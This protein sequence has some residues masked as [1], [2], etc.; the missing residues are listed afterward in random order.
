VV[1]TLL[2]VDGVDRGANVL[3]DTST[4]PRIQLAVAED[5]IGAGLE[6]VSTGPQRNPM[7]SD[8]NAVGLEATHS[9]LVDVPSLIQK[10]ICDTRVKSA[11]AIFEFALPLTPLEETGNTNSVQA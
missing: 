7:R 8:G 11:F 10:H 6:L 9:V 1:S 4:A 5:D 2:D 3:D